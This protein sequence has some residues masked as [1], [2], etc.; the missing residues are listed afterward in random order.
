[1]LIS[2]NTFKYLGLASALLL[3]SCSNSFD[4]VVTTSKAGI[5]LNFKKAGV[6][7]SRLRP[8]L[9]TLRIAL[10]GDPEAES[11]HLEA[12]NG[13]CVVV[14]EVTLGRVPAGLQ[15]MVAFLP[16]KEGVTYRIEAE[17]QSGRGGT[18]G[19]WIFRPAQPPT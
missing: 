9:T 5:K 18:S 15:Q 4:I 10:D 2:M 3:S 19:P 1:M 6:F 14:E 12:S 17:E 8:C 7:G 13:R 16:L 11:W